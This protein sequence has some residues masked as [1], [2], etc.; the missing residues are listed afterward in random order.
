MSRKAK[1]TAPKT[2]AE[3]PARRPSMPV[4]KALPLSLTA[5][6]SRESEFAA[7]LRRRKLKALADLIADV[8]EEFHGQG[9]NSLMAEELGILR[10]AWGFQ[11]HGALEVVHM[12][13]AEMD[14]RNQLK[15]TGLW[16]LAEALG[17]CQP[18][19]EARP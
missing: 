17:Q 11:G 12:A 2:R 3:T 6:L 19:A 4:I 13:A 8:H 9:L 7:W 16:A 5:P 1:K 15:M 14:R 18:A 10:S